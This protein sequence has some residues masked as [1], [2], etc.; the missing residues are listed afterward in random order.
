MSIE[1]DLH[2]Y[3]FINLPSTI[4]LMADLNAANLYYEHLAEAVSAIKRRHPYLRMKIISS[5][6]A[7]FAFKFNEQNEEEK[8]LIPIDLFMVDHDREAESWSDKLIRAANSAHDLTKS[9]FFFEIYSFTGTDRHQ[10][11][12][13]INH[14]GKQIF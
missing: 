12:L 2:L 14:S 6:T 9:V 11:F 7:Q 5:P 10:I 3:E 1:R 13:G 4:C 8:Q